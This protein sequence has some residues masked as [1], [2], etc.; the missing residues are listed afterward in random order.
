MCNK[1]IKSKL[2]FSIK[3]Y[4]CD[5]RKTDFICDFNSIKSQ[6][7]VHQIDNFCVDLE[8][9]NNLRIDAGLSKFNKIYNRKPSS[10]SNE[11][12]IFTMSVLNE[13][14]F[15]NI[16]LNNFYT[17]I[18]NIM[19]D[20]FDILSFIVTKDPIGDLTLYFITTTVVKKI[21]LNHV[22]SRIMESGKNPQDLIGVLSYNLILGGTKAEQPEKKFI[23]LLLSR[24]NENELF[25]LEH[26]TETEKMHYLIKS[27]DR[28]SDKITKINDEFNILINEF[29][30]KDARYKKV[31]EDIIRIKN[32]TNL[33]IK[34]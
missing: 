23:N 30:K 1:N 22:E 2:A 10:L 21:F 13:N 29:I 27:Y 17:K 33:S 31:F 34:Q 28:A 5:T 14:F 7:I 3:K 11:N 9:E 12:L 8:W 4:N 26:A 25:H 16:D 24:I 19:N 18:Y 20:Y 15:E 32:L 6:N